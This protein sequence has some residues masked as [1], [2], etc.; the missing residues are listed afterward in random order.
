MEQL[1]KILA[2]S[3][4]PML[5]L[6]KNTICAMN[7]AARALL[8]GFEV[9]GSAVGLIPDYILF[10]QTDSFTA[11]MLLRTREFTV[12]CAHIGQY[13]ALSLQSVRGRSLSLLSEGL[14]NGM[15]NALFNVDLASRQLAKEES[16][17]PGCSAYLSMLRHNF[18]IL[19]RQLSNLSFAIALQERSAIFR[20]VETDLVKFIRELTD[21][22]ASLTGEDSAA[23]EFLTTL[24][25]VT[26]N[27]DRDKLRR[28][29]LNLLSNSF[30]HCEPDGH[31]RLRLSTHG[32]DA[33]I[34]VADDGSGIP[35]E[36]LQTVFTRFE[37]RIRGEYTDEVCSGGLGLGIA[38]G[39]A[40]LH[41][42]AMVID[43]T[44]GVGTNVRVLLPLKQPSTLLDPGVPFKES[45]LNLLFTELSDVLRAEVYRDEF[46]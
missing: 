45:G 36:T 24:P 15:R 42:G 38:R 14:L 17:K 31:I 16:L 33:V 35:P 39:V 23:L 26:A 18:H 43:S 30:A 2:L 7:A 25:S 11:T 34:T 46:E 12:S 1:E 19:N 37:K 41:G 3:H 8:P 9:G 13:L 32:D 28:L 44:P 22:V 6:E 5:I 4:D 40:Q 20:P 21:E 27:V 10:N 29:L